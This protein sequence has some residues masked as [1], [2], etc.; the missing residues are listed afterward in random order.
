MRRNSFEKILYMVSGGS[1]YLFSV[2]LQYESR[3]S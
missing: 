2:F 3:L 1:M